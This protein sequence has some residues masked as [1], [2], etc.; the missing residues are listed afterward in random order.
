MKK[1]MPKV[2]DIVYSK[3]GVGIITKCLNDL[4][5]DSETAYEV[6]Y[7]EVGQKFSRIKDFTKYL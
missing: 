4:F 1:R 3:I 7:F 5:G 2:G 6:D